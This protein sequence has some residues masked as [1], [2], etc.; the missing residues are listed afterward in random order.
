MAQFSRFDSL[1]ATTSIHHVS[2]QE[3]QLGVRYES[4]HNNGEL[5]SL[6]P[7]D[8]PLYTDWQ[9]SSFSGLATLSDYEYEGSR[10]AISGGGENPI[11]VPGLPAGASFGN[12]IHDLLEEFDFE[13]LQSSA[14]LISQIE[15]K[16]ERYGVEAN[17]HDVEKLLGCVVSA[18]LSEGF[19]L[20]DIP[21]SQCL[22]EM[23]FY[24]Q[25][26]PFQTN[27][28]N[29]VLESDPTVLPVGEKEMRGYL[30]G[31][32][33]LICLKDGKYYIMDYKT[34]YLGG[35]LSTYQHNFLVDAMKSHNYGLQY[36]IYSMVLHRHL[37]N[38]LDDYSY[39]VHFGGVMYLFVRGLSP[40][41][42]GSG[43]YSTLP[44]YETLLRLEALLSGDE[45]DQ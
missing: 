38:L 7:S 1:A 44:D 28:I 15:R 14:G 5:T 8:R 45:D 20:M 34:N 40:D 41:H 36:W 42:P 31:Y 25:L 27:S 29:D 17:T 18:P 43:V 23:P 12:V 24:F 6:T 30:T 13:S 9:M 26:S 21:S 11:D 16:C 22:K 35:D 33:D 39:D 10:T 37:K 2:I 32:V 19:R 4:E 3:D